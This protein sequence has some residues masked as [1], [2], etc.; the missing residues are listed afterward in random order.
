MEII[1]LLRKIY[2]V[3]NYSEMETILL[4]Y[5]QYIYVLWFYTVFI[6]FTVQC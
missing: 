6:H 4:F 3:I 5:F 1:V 2:C